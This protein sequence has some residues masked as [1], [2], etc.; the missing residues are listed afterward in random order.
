MNVGGQL[1]LPTHSA[2]VKTMVWTAHQNRCTPTV[3]WS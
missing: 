1:T 3:C 2:T